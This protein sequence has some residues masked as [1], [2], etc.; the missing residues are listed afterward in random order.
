MPWLYFFASLRTPFFDG[1]FSL[2]THIGEETLFLAA[3]I[4]LFW[5]VSKREGYYV[6]LTGLFGTVINQ[7]L[8]LIFR[9]PRPWVLDPDFTIVESARAEATGYSFP[10]GHTQNVAGTFGSVAAYHRRRWLSAVC[11]VLILL[12]AFSRMYLGVHTP[13]DVFV[14]LGIA[15]VLVIALAPVFRSQER[16]DR[17]MPFLLAAAYLFTLALLVF[18]FRGVDPAA[19]DPQNLLSGREN[20]CSLHGSVLGFCLVYFLDRRWLRFDTRGAWYAQI[21]KL[22][23]GFALVLLLKAGLK[24]P[25][26]ALCGGNAYVGRVLRYFLVVMFA[27]TVWPL[28]FRFFARFRVAPL[29]RWT[30]RLCQRR[31]HAPAASQTGEGKSE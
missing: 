5:C 6:L 7:G 27:G 29:D 31:C 1:F 17:A 18:V 21:V 11:A 25:L 16:T 30:A 14:S 8:K 15:A 12:V 2:V 3:A 20:A 13:K 26:N 24:A 9:I 28:T 19:T 10:S 23:T 22:V 4:F